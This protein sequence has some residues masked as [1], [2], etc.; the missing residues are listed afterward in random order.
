MP[1]IVDFR[2]SH[3]KLNCM[4]DILAGI[5]H[6][7]SLNIVHRDIKPHNIL[8]NYGTGNDRLVISDFGL[9]KKLGDQQMSY[10][11]SVTNG[12]GSH[13]WRAPEILAV[14]S[15]T[16]SDSE[17]GHLHKLSMSVDVFA[18]GLVFFFIMSE[19]DHAYG[20][21]LL[22]ENN[23]VNDQKFLGQLHS[24][25]PVE[26]HL[27]ERMLE[28]D[29]KK[30]PTAAA[31][32]EHVAFWSPS[33]RLS[34][35]LDLSDRLDAEDR[36]GELYQRFQA[37]GRRVISKRGWMDKVD[38]ELFHDLGKYRKYDKDSLA[39]LL[40]AIRNKKHHYQELPT[41]MKQ[42][43]GSIPEGYYEYFRKRFP[44]LDVVAYQF[45]DETELFRS[46]QLMRPY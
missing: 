19:G 6:L 41:Q 1:Q 35:L 43:F 16:E 2:N 42:L 9:C 27:I 28:A 31:S 29:S 14:L 36:D 12:A 46:D 23:I 34:F 32:L 5:R 20:E 3:S 25:N 18:A 37:L 21:H 13:G 8:I 38:Q 15:P 4:A 33:R 45:V 10:M 40:R 22:R 7:H 30:R 39:D 24:E 11:H 44:K 17:P 26:C